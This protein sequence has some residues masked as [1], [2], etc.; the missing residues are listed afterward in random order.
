MQR[1][2]EALPETSKAVAPLICAEDTEI[3][4]PTVTEWPATD[5]SLHEPDN[6]FYILLQS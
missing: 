3:V 6:A 5:L 1:E 2:R 4:S